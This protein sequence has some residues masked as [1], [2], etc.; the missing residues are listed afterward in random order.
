[1]DSLPLGLPGKPIG[2]HTIG[3]LLKEYIYVLAMSGL[4]SG[5]KAS[6]SMW[7]SGSSIFRLSDCGTHATLLCSM[8]DL[9]SPARD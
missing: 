5:A 7:G 1:M 8:W 4:S 2:P 6:L 9:S 3:L